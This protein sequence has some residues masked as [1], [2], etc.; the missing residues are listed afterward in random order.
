MACASAA[1]KI[2]QEC[3]I[4]VVFIFLLIG[5][6]IILSEVSHEKKQYSSK[7]GWYFLIVFG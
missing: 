2:I 5:V 4:V 3:V 7:W 6:S 1:I